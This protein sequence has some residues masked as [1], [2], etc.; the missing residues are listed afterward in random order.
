MVDYVGERKGSNGLFTDEGVSINLKEL[1]KN[2]GM[3][4]KQLSLDTN[5]PESTIKTPSKL[6]A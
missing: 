1:K 5:I 2:K 6:A 4:C 3:T